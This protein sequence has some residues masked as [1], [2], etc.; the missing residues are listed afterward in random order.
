RAVGECLSRESQTRGLFGCD[1]IFDGKV[2]WLTEVNPRY[3]ASAELFDHLYEASLVDWHCRACLAFEMKA[4]SAEI[5]DDLTTA[6]SS[7]VKRQPNRFLGKVILYAPHDFT[8]PEFAF[9][10]PV[11]IGLSR[12]PKL[13]DIPVPGTFIRQ[14]EPFCT[15]LG[16]G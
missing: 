2:P 13:A 5:I 9:S 10:T 16:T 14:A 12:I 15:L 8:A 7:G 3:T 11:N 4:R 1:F 6:I